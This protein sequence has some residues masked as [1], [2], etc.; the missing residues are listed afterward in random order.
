VKE[1]ALS[2]SWM[3]PLS[4][5]QQDLVCRAMPAVNRL[6]RRMA[7]RRGGSYEELRQIGAVALA[8]AVR[9]YDEGRGISLEMFAW[10]AIKGAMLDHLCRESAARPERILARLFELDAAESIEDTGDPFSDTDEERLDRINGHCRAAALE[11][12]VRFAGGA[13]L[14][15]GE[16][17]LIRDLSRSALKRAC[18]T[19]LDEDENRIVALH[20][21]EGAT[22]Q[23]AAALIGVSESTVKRRGE[24][25]QRKLERCLRER[26][27]PSGG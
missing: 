18:E 11:L 21:G 25:I 4:P 15:Q 1:G 9:A 3:L 17:G 20:Y 12:F 22:W 24:Q 16:D 26:G 8:E 5:K 14:E 2:P 13:W 7:R 19:V 6:A 27:V 10:K 23:E